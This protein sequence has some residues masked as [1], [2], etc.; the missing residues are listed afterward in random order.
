M[1]GMKSISLMQ[2]VAMAVLME[3]P[4]TTSRRSGDDDSV[5]FPF[6][7]GTGAVGSALSRSTLSPPQ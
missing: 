7:G 6:T 4:P 5:D 2:M 1:K 3:M